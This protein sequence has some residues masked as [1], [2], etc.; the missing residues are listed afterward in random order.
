MDITHEKEKEMFICTNNNNLVKI[1]GTKWNSSKNYKEPF[2]NIALFYESVAH[3]FDI[4]IFTDKEFTVEGFTNFC[5]N[6]FE[7]KNGYIFREEFFNIYD[8]MKS[9]TKAAFSSFNP[10]YISVFSRRK[11]LLEKAIIICY[12]TSDN[13]TKTM[14]FITKTTI[15]PLDYPGTRDDEI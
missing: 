3:Y 7:D 8:I 6:F 4:N 2:I 15:P 14:N 10:K 12:S 11:R 5:Q 1:I 9:L 13:E